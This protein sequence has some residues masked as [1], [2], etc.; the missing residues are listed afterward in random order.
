MLSRG[1]KLVN[2]KD[3]F[4]VAIYLGVL[5][6]F[7]FGKFPPEGF[8]KLTKDLYVK[9]LEGPNLEDWEPY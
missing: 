4:R 8:S 2:R 9:W 7:Y 5:V 6:E 3:K 1:Q